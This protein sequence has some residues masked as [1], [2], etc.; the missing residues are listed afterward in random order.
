MRKDLSKDSSELSNLASFLNSE[1]SGFTLMEVVVAIA[2][3]G[4]GLTVII[5]LFSGGLRLGKVSEEYTRA[6]HYASLK[7][8]E[9]AAQKTIEE[10]EEE[11]EFDTTFRW[12]VAVQKKDIL[13]LDRGTE[14]KPPADFYHVRIRVFWMSGTKERSASLETYKT[15]KT[16]EADEKKS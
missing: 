15:L 16:S 1:N 7:L 3:L 5:E 9:V 10:G 6:V 14:F 4:I 11:G 12:Q 8:E 2:I 13:L